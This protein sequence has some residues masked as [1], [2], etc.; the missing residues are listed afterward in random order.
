MFF[1]KLFVALD[2]LY[3]PLFRGSKRK[4]WI[5]DVNGRMARVTQ[6]RNNTC[7]SWRILCSISASLNIFYLEV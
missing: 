7:A 2:L 4:G 5:Y 6:L 1:R 3:G